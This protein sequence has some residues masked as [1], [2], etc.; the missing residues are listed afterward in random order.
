[1]KKKGFTLIETLIYLALFSVIMAG[2]LTSVYSVSQTSSRNQTKAMILE[3]GT[4]LSAKIDWV[5]SNTSEVIWPVSASS[6]LS[7]ITFDGTEII[8][9]LNNNNLRIARGTTTP[10]ILNNT[11]VWISNLSFVHSVESGVGINPESLEA[12]F[13]ANA[14]T[15]DGISLSQDFS[16]IKYLRR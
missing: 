8:I 12:S 6:S 4:F 10:E 2:I 3:E 1:M 11:N 9:D 15:P 13:T 5:F 14:R 7:V 16:T